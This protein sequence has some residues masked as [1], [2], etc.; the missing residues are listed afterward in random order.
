[1]P[2]GAGFSLLGEVVREIESAEISVRNDSGGEL[3]VDGATFVSREI[4][5]DSPGKISITWKDSF[6][7]TPSAPCSL[8]IRPTADK[9]PFVKCPGLSPFTAILANEVLK[10]TIK[11][12]DDYGIRSVDAEYVV[13]SIDGAKSAEKE[14]N[15]VALVAG[16]KTTAKL[17]GMFTFSPKLMGIKEKTMLTL[18]GTAGDFKPGRGQSRSAPHKIYVLSREQHARIVADRLKRV[19]A[20]MEDMMRR[21]EES[22]AENEK[23]SKLSD[24][25]M[26]TK[27]TGEKV[28]AQSDKELG[29]KRELDKLIAKTANLLKE[30]LRNNKFPNDAITK[31]SEFLEK[32]KSMSSSDM[33][34]MLKHL[35]KAASKATRREK[36]L[37]KAIKNQRAMLDKLK[38]C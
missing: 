26:A 36:E 5:A 16:G 22:L 3:S 30:A 19:M 6:G 28:K 8:E 21:E 34:K 7:M 18:R 25:K 32:M 1:L 13:N 4:R 29:E 23:I 2:I 12:E 10:I 24:K 27:K 9:A 31:W 17:A 33:P 15:V 11:A 20:D 37:S 35:D 14:K 38:R